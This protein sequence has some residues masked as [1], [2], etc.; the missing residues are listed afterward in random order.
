LPVLETHA[1]SEILFAV[2]P[3]GVVVLHEKAKLSAGQR[4]ILGVD[5]PAAPPRRIRLDTSRLNLAFTDIVRLSDL[6]REDSG[7]TVGPK[8][9]NLGQLSQDFPGRVAGGLVLPFGVY[10]QHIQRILP[11]DSAPL[12]EQVRAAYAEAEQMSQRAAPAEVQKFIYPRLAEFRR[13]IQGMA[14]I[15]EF[16]AELLRRLQSDLETPGGAAGVFVR[17]DTNAEDLPEFTGAGLNLTV[18][19][20]VGAQQIIQAI[21]NVW[22]SPFTERAYEWRSRFRSAPSRF[23]LR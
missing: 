9:A 4:E 3:Q 8:A 20:Q 10:F 14:L 12:I 16:E 13:K 6:G 5:K 22:A 17:S 21:K 18:P 2:T 11:G 19:N 15:P 23:I 7:V 1:G